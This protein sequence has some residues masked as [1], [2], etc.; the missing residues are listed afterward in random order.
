MVRPAVA[1]DVAAITRIVQN[2]YAKYVARIGKKPAPMLDDYTAHVESG[3]VWVTER[4]GEVA[5]L[6]V[7]LE[8]PDHLLLDNIAVD[9]AA[10]GQG[11]GRALLDF[12]AKE[13]RRRGHA[14][15]RLYTNA[16]MTENLALYPRLGWIE[17]GHAIQDGY[18]RVFFRKPV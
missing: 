5:G 10:Q 7:L 12:A 6:V 4:G 2:A 17:D 8:R 1:A 15:M 11:V 13:A 18:D 16:A 9:P 3:D 14:E